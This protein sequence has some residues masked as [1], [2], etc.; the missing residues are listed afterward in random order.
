[1]SLQHITSRRNGCA[2]CCTIVCP[3][4]N[5]TFPHRRTCHERSWMYYQRP[6]GPQSRPSRR[7]HPT[8]P[9]GETSSNSP[10][11]HSLPGR[12]AIHWPRCST[13]FTLGV[14]LVRHAVSRSCHSLSAGKACH[15]LSAVRP[16]SHLLLG[17]NDG[18]PCAWYRSPR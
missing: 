2:C 9:S 12:S 14:L 18:L 15:L 10:A 3:W 1:M 6:L 16:R 11:G 5:S 8:S 7:T 17:R 4:H 13:F